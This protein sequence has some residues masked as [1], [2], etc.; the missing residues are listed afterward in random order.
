MAPVTPRTSESENSASSLSVLKSSLKME[1]IPPDAPSKCKWARDGDPT[2]SPHQII[3]SPRGFH[4]L[5]SIL[6]CIGNT[7][8]VKINKVG[9]DLDCDIYAKLEFLNPGGSVKDRIGL[10]MVQEAER[11]GLIKPGYTLIEP[12]S[13]NTGIGIALA[14]AVRGYRAIIVMPEKMSNEKVDVLRALGAEIVRTPTSARFDS[15]ESHISVAQ[16]L[17]A[18]IPHSIILDQYRNP[19]NPL[20]HYDSTAE[21]IL[22]QM[23]GKVDMVVVSAGTG[24]TI[25]GIGRKLKEKCP[26]CIVVG[27]DPHG[28]I[29]AEPASLNVSEGS[30]EV[31][32]I[33]YDFVPTVL[34]RS[35]VDKWIKSD[36]LSS[37]HMS[38]RLMKEEGLL[39]GGSCGSAMS[40]AL[41]AA[42]VLKKGQKC[43][44]ILP[45]GVR[46]Y[47]TKFLS[48]QW[49]ITKGFMDYSSL[50]E[51]LHSWS[52]KLV[53]ALELNAPLTV[54]PMCSCQD[55]IEIMNKEN[56]DQ[57]PVVDESSTILGMV[58]LG[59]LI[60]KI[61]AK[62]IEPWSPVSEVVYNQF[63]KIS[64]NTSLGR[65]SRILDQ[66]HYALV[67]HKQQC[68]SEKGHKVEKEVIIGI[69]SRIDLLNYITAH[70]S[71]DE[72]T[73]GE[74]R[75]NGAL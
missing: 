2:T 24:G 68:Y 39:C 29:L 3:S 70:G 55:A 53:T 5:D 51:E 10:R 44:V 19:G 62:K 26:D 64:L 16:R 60:S 75:N 27:V 21:E 54:L 45:D 66:D 50:D 25:A 47:M 74:K 30:Y 11:S 57:L 17:Q 38:R 41:E 23:G 42:K 73:N 13:G 49:M 15:P 37:F 46:N 71:L 7:P 6:D 12:T 65:L 35:V 14:A 32:G 22:E 52:N 28:S 43:V 33:G 18:E 4:A 48:D 31:E 36:D 72:K 69:V 58:T 63:K 59:N 8:I 56:F 9:K 61:L 40:A 1:F 34:D 20:A 67:V